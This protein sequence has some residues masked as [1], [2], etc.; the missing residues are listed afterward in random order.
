M[1]LRACAAWHRRADFHALDL[2]LECWL[3][4]AVIRLDAFLSRRATRIIYVGQISKRQHEVFTTGGTADRHSCSGKRRVNSRVRPC[5][6]LMMDTGR[7]RH[8]TQ[9]LDATSYMLTP[10]TANT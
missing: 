4:A 5:T 9:D 6:L 3:T 10:M 8:P 2:S 7:D 1:L